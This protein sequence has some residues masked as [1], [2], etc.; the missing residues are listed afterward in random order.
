MMEKLGHLLDRPTPQLWRRH[1]AG[2]ECS[3]R[4]KGTNK[5]GSRGTPGEDGT[6]GGHPKAIG[7]IGWDGDRVG[8]KWKVGRVG[9]FGR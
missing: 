3:F 6:P 1:V 2:E 4:A 5:H 9:E 7:I 8:R